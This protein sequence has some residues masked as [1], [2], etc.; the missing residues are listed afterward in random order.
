MNVTP[1]SVTVKGNRGTILDVDGGQTK[2]PWQG[3]HPR[4]DDAGNFCL[5]AVERDG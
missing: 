5:F 1:G 4:H 3:A 2:T